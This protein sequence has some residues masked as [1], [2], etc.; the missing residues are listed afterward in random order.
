MNE[1]SK[2]ELPFVSICTPTYNRAHMLDA[3]ARYIFLQDYPKDRME[4]LVADDSTDN[5]LEK[6]EE[7]RERLPNLRVF[8]FEGRSGNGIKR[9]WLIERAAGDILVHFDDDDYYSPHRVSHAVESLQNSDKLIAG[10][11]MLYIWHVKEQVL[12]KSGPFHQ[13]HA[14]NATFAYKKEYAEHNRFADVNQQTE[15]SFTNNFTNPMIQLDSLKTM[16]CIKHNQNTVN[17]QIR[18]VI[19]KDL[20]KVISDPIALALY[21]KK[22]TSFSF[23][24]FN[25]IS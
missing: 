25:Q 17:K 13:N 14:T 9:Q 2:K 18:N 23:S 20:S 1:M 3:W 12:T 10:C 24:F 4:V 11:T 7:L 22:S 16:V 15:P 8:N 5:T 6:L 21:T 19:T